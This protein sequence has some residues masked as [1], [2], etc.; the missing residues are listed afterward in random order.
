MAD[1][2]YSNRNRE[3][4]KYFLNCPVR[5]TGIWPVSCLFSGGQDAHSTPIQRE[6]ISNPS[7]KCGSHINELHTPIFSR[8]PIPDSRF[9]I[10]DSLFPSPK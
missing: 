7:D 9:P 8:F 2:I 5:G 4:T 10:P 6:D 3:V 1:Y